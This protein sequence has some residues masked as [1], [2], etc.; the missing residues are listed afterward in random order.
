ML[1][2]LFLVLEG[3]SIPLEELEEEVPGDREVWE[4]HFSPSVA[5]NGWVDNIGI[6]KK[7]R[8]SKNSKPIYDH[9]SI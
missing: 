1:N 7:T 6:T 8:L 4:S 5:K 2:L 9:R 3:L